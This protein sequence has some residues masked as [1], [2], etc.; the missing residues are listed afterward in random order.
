[1][2]WLDLERQRGAFRVVALEQKK[3]FE[4]CGVRVS[5]SLDRIDEL[6][7]GSRVVLDYKTGQVRPAGWFG[8]RPG[9][10]QLPLYAVACRDGGGNAAL[11]GV[12]AAQIRPQ[13]PAFAGVVRDEGILPGLPV[14]RKGPLAEAAASWPAV[15]DDWSGVLERL[16]AR[17]HSG[18]AEVDPKNGLRT[19]RESYCELG[20]LCRIRERLA[21]SGD[22]SGSAADGTGP[23]G[24]GAE[25]RQRG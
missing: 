23:G 18:A 11:A 16:A 2:E 14:R 15:L 13:G 20:P 8:E 5:L 25:G 17:F 24:Q 3:T 22:E 7:D 9:E 1:M 4:A 19:C 6:E 21:R 12:A 10:P